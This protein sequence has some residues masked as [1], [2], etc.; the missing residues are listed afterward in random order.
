VVHRGEGHHAGVFHLPEGELGL[1]LRAVGGD[2]VGDGPVV[3]VSDQDVLAEDLFFQRGARAGVDGP[4]QPQ[5][6]WLAAV[7]LPGD[8]AADPGFAGDRGD[9]G[10]DLAAGA[11]GLAAGQ[12]GGQ[13]V[14]PLAGFGQGGAV[15]PGGLGG[16]QLG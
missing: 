1:G 15:E 5:G 6:G 7:Q 9:L 3:V 12:R 14:Q 13:L 16:V 8:D 4:G 2:D 10:L 11:A